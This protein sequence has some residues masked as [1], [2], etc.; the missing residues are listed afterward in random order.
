M[1]LDRF[2]LNAD[3][4]KRQSDEQLDWVRWDFQNKLKFIQK[5]KNNAREEIDLI[6]NLIK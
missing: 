5:R 6:K 1:I 3:E 2:N 4:L